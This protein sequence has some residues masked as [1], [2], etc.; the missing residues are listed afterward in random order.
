MK[1]CVC[2]TVHRRSHMNGRD[3]WQ[4]IK[5]EGDA[6]IPA[7]ILPPTLLSR[8]AYDLIWTDL[9]GMSSRQSEMAFQ[10][11]CQIDPD[12]LYRRALQALDRSI[13]AKR[14]L[15][16]A[17]NEARCE[18]MAAMM[19]KYPQAARCILKQ[20]DMDRPVP[21]LQPKGELVQLAPRPA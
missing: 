2:S 14:L 21:R 3:W 4:R 1:L 15:E 18:I 12:G 9:L 5:R 20:I 11:A 19:I 17:Y 10:A 16:Q 7:I 8:E 13:T 6:M